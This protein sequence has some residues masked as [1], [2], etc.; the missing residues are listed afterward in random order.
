MREYRIIYSTKTTALK[1]C[2]RDWLKFQIN[3]VYFMF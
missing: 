3:I 2:S 1:N